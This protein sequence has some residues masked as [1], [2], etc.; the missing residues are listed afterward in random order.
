[1]HF[2]VYILFAIAQTPL[3]AP[4]D[5]NMSK[6]HNGFEIISNHLI[7]YKGEYVIKNFAWLDW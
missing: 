3:L 6:Q 1:M 4:G 5:A 7:N 2:D